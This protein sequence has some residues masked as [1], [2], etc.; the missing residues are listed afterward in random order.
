LRKIITFSVI[1]LAFSANAQISFIGF[2]TTNCGSP[3]TNVYTFTNY[4][5]GFWGHGYTIFKNGIQ[6]YDKQNS[7]GDCYC[8]EL[9]FINDTIGFMAELGEMYSTKV[10]KS[11]DFGSNWTL[12]GG[13]APHYFG[14]FI[15]NKHYGYFVSGINNLVLV[16]SFSDIQIPQFEIYDT[17][18]NKDIFITDTI[19]NS[20]VILIL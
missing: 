19:Y 10:Y 5:F 3:L 17:A 18:V 8:L 1:L 7:S 12:I 14:L 9:I 11:S 4:D 15:V 16:T 2:D 13:G 6:V 20:L